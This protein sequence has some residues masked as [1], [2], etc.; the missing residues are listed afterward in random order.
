MKALGSGGGAAGV[1]AAATTSMNE[2]RIRELEELGFVWALRNNSKEGTVATNPT[3]DEM[4]AAA[5][6]ASLAVERDDRVMEMEDHG[7]VPNAMAEI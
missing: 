3:E 5:V 1:T 6:A 4:A 7:M 2:D